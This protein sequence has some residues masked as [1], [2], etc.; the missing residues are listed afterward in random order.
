M[1]S[2]TAHPTL[3]RHSPPEVVANFKRRVPPRLPKPRKRESTD[4]LSI[5]PPRSALGL[6]PV[7][8][9]VPSSHKPV[10]PQIGRA[11]GFSAPGSFTP[12][13]QAGPGAWSNSPYSHRSALPPL[14]VPEPQ[15]NIHNN[16]H[17]PSHHTLP[18]P[19][20]PAEESTFA[21]SSNPYPPS[22]TYHPEQG[23]NWSFSPVSSSSSSHNGSLSS[24]LNPSTHNSGYTRPTPTINTS[25]N[26]SP[27]SSMPMEHSSSSLSPD[28]HSRPTTGY[29]MSSVSSMG[30]GDDHMQHDYHS[31][32]RP[33][34]SHHHGRPM[35][36]PR[37][38]SSK[39][40]YSNSLSIRRARRHSQALS[41]YPSPMYEHDQRPSTS[42]QPASGHHAHPAHHSQQDTGGVPRVRSMIQLPSVLPPVEHYSFSPQAE[43]AYSGPGP[44]EYRPSTGNGRPSTGTSATS[45]S[46]ANTPPVT[47][48]FGA[49]TDI[50]RCESP[51]VLTSVFVC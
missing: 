29:S 21:Y 25:Y 14:T 51:M 31:S 27:F 40:P 46:H 6:G 10:P 17:H 5:P 11:R 7:P 37:P 43:F 36:P 1:T 24:L 12:L 18:P 50:N 22:N 8:L 44:M 35:T 28:S 32:S 23:N 9:T 19:I 33:S 42:P 4:A 48:G 2:S 45:S 30:Y 13:S 38:S 34:S 49:E 15:H 16:Y 47:D 26:S 20:S 39:S 41:P 3:N